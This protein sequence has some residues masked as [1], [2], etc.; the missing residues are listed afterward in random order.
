[1]RVR[2]LLP[3]AGV[4]VSVGL[5]VIARAMCE[6]HPLLSEPIIVGGILLA[7]WLFSLAG[8]YGRTLRAE[9]GLRL[10]GTLWGLGVI[11]LL[12]SLGL[13][14]GS[15]LGRCVFSALWLGPELAMML[16]PPMLQQAWDGEVVLVWLPAGAGAALLFAAARAATEP[17]RASDT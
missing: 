5:A 10:A 17:P 12:M 16:A 15:Y 13:A 14:S 1:M 2:L 7:V 8:G 9:G 11:A 3:G 6:V 4:V